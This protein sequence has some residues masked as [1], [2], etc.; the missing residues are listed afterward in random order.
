MEKITKY[1]VVVAKWLGQCLDEP[2]VILFSS[3]LLLKKCSMARAALQAE[4]TA[5]P[6]PIEEVG[7]N[8]AA[9]SPMARKL[10]FTEESVS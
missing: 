8:A 5:K 3:P 7:S 6:I 1:L 10:F 9:A 4:E 2:M